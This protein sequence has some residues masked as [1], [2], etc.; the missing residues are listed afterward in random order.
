[1]IPGARVQAA[2]EIIDR[3]A[4]GH[5]SL[6]RVIANWGRRNRYAGSGDRRAIADLVHDAVRRL[7]SAAW[8]AGVDEPADGRAVMVGSLLLDGHGSDGLESLFSG[9]RHAPAPL[10]AD[11]RSRV[12]RPLSASSWAVRFDVPDWLEPRLSELPEG[13]VGALANRA[14][15]FLRANRLRTD[16]AGAVAALTADGIGVEPG[17]RAPDC[18]RVVSG[19]HKVA[20]SEAYRNGLVEIQ[21]ASS[22]AVAAYALARPGEIVLDYCAGGGGKALALA[23]DMCGHGEVHLHDVAPARLAQAAGRS[24]R[25][26]ARIELHAPGDLGDLTGRC[27]LVFADVPC[28]GSGAWRRNPDEK[29]RLTEEKLANYVE[30]QRTI[31]DDAVRMLRPGGRLIYAT[32][33]I[34]QDENAVACEDFRGTFPGRPP[35]RLLPGDDGDGFFACEFLRGSP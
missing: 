15:L 4:A 26:G 25:A 34:L 20:G 11:E 12:G 27:D 5:E 19:A 35:L 28:S 17:P 1:M 23:A 24:R 7:R 22:Q 14:P 21:D 2:I 30:T 18:L 3:W 16:V 32:C 9:E 33:S 8:V 6:S 29:W 31:L 13:A 10:S